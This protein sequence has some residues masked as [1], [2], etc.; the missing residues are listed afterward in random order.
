[1]AAPS[2]TKCRFKRKFD[3]KAVNGCNYLFGKRDGTNKDRYLAKFGEP[4]EP[5]EGQT[6]G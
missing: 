2:T 1:M 3:T 4:P 6:D 5:K